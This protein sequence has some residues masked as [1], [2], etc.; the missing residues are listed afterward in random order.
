MGRPSVPSPLS[1]V[2]GHYLRFHDEAAG[3]S[4][5]SLEEARLQSPPTRTGR[6]GTPLPVPPVGH[7]RGRA[8]RRTLWGRW[9]TAHKLLVAPARAQRT[10][11]LVSPLRPACAR[12]RLEGRMST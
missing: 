3:S 9:W 8:T 10:S 11:R 12:K 7:R 6:K 1:A 5:E 2:L 4:R